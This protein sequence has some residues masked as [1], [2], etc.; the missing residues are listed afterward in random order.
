MRAALAMIAALSVGISTHAQSLA[1]LARQADPGRAGTQQR[2]ADPDDHTSAG[3]GPVTSVYTNES[4]RSEA[5]SRPAAPAGPAQIGLRAPVPSNAATEPAAVVSG[6]PKV[7]IDQRTIERALALGRATDRERAQFH[8][9]YVFPLRGLV[10][11]RVEVLTEFRRVV[12]AS[13]EQ[14]RFG[15]RQFGVRETLPL[16]QPW[17]GRVSIVAHVRFHPHN[18]YVEVPP[19]ELSLGEG[20]APPETQRTPI[21]GTVSQGTRYLQGAEVQ[22][23]FD[24]A[25]LM[26]EPRTLVVRLAQEELAAVRIDFGSLE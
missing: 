21:F 18:T 2:Q 16:V 7:H 19:Y 6:N 14:V 9:R 15:N 1:D 25:Q 13:E 17:R 23:T 4:L 22:A 20:I 10:V 8:G 26:Q 24:G 3:R 12:L 5:A 11:E